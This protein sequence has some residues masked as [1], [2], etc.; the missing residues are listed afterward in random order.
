MGRNGQVEGDST[1]RRKPHISHPRGFT[2]HSSGNKGVPVR[3]ATDLLTILQEASVA[4][5]RTA[6]PAPTFISPY[7][8][9]HLRP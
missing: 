8:N 1:H 4:A 2:G 7:T 6:S 5:R 3:W 9:Y